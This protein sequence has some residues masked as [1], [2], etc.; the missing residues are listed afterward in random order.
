M[1]SS[2]L[3]ADRAE[4]ADAGA[5]S[6]PAGPPARA[7]AQPSVIRAAA[8]GAVRLNRLVPEPLESVAEPLDRLRDEAF[9]V[10]YDEG[11][12]RAAEEAAAAAARAA[13]EH[14]A[15][16]SAGLSLLENA[17]LLVRAQLSEE[18]DRLERAATRLAMGLTEEILQRELE[19]AASPG[20]D[21]IARALRLVPGD[22]PAV[23][24][25]NPADLE[26]LSPVTARGLRLEP[27]PEI[28]R[29]G[30]QL[31][32]GATLVDARIETA[33]QRVRAVLEQAG[34]TGE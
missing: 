31:D 11:R 4:G 21:A 26:L 19:L 30:C 29:G 7:A 8:A 25:C 17:A 18:V 14:E 5:A 9:R 1:S 24:R 27:D 3:L 16:I 6:T 12:R 2:P 22:T 15:R 32:T 28:G 20:A 33:L 34:G 13:A 10:G 23:V